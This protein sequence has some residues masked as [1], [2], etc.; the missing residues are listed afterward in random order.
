VKWYLYY[1]ETFL[2]KHIK[3]SALL[4]TLSIILILT[5]IAMGFLNLNLFEIKFNLNYGN[6]IQVKWASYGMWQMFFY[7]L[8]NNKIPLQYLKKRTYINNANC[9]LEFIPENNFE[10]IIKIKAEKM[11]Q[12][13]KFKKIVKCLSFTY[14]SLLYN[15]TL[16]IYSPDKQ[17]FISAPVYASKDINIYLT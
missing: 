13:Y 11:G 6:Y 14:F 9:E 2:Y 12:K 3:G 1:L 4:V 16:N 7:D 5:I 17:L 15:D 10:F 8:K